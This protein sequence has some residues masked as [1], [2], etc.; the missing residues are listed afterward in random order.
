METCFQH[1]KST[2]SSDT[3]QSMKRRII[4]KQ[5]TEL[6]II[7]RFILWRVSDEKVLSVC[8]KCFRFYAIPKQWKTLYNWK[9]IQW[10]T[11]LIKRQR[12]AI[13]FTR[14][15]CWRKWQIITNFG[16]LHNPMTI[17]ESLRYYGCI[18]SHRL[19]AK[20]HKVSNI[21]GSD[22]CVVRTGDVYD[23]LRS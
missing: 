13:R 15:R 22:Q 23:L 9:E 20:N 5:L 19:F 18:N 6:A 11:R 10:I 16:K 3:R 12:N 2:F 4:A 7:R 14:K 8:R 17:K 1:T 21:D